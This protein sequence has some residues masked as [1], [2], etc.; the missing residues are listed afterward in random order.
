MTGKSD[1]VATALRTAILRGDYEDG[2]HLSQPKLA[3]QYGVHRSVVSQA[4][5]M[6]EFEGYVSKDMEHR[7]HANASYQTRQLQMV[8]TM[9][10]HIE[11]QCGR[12]L[13]ALT[14]ERSHT[15]TP[16]RRAMLRKMQGRRGGS[17]VRE[18]K[19]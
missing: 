3:L 17:A 10:D 6:L 13:I 12:S 2:E 11:W 5:Y 9:L 19:T 15:M 7:Y 8:L 16:G 4:L 14:G 18:H 1:H